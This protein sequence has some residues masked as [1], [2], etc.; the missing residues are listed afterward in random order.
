MSRRNQLA[1][2]LGEAK[3]GDPFAQ[4]MLGYL[5]E[6][7]IGTTADRSAAESWYRHAAERNFPPAQYAL[8]LS[9]N[10][11]GDKMAKQLLEKAARNA[12]PPAQFAFACVILTREPEAGN[13][14][15]ALDLLTQ[16]SKN[17]YIPATLQLSYIYAGDQFPAKRDVKLALKLA[18]QAA[19]AGSTEGKGWYGILALQHGG[20]RHTDEALNYLREAA[21]LGDLSASSFLASVYLGGLYGVEKNEKSAK[22]YHRMAISAE[23]K[24]KTQKN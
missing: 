7:G 16:A 17:G 24:N 14:E 20:E 23:R 22:K 5:H 13:L 21:E 15:A 8:A 6:H 1:K 4:V 19:A 11:G 12:H 10:G 2:I 9:S 3:D 18:M